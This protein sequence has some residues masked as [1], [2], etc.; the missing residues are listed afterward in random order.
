MK[1]KIIN[2]LSFNLS[3]VED[4]RNREVLEMVLVVSDSP[5]KKIMSRSSEENNESVL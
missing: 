3:L 2:S 5:L 1:M 4:T